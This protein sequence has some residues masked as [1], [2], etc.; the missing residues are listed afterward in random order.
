MSTLLGGGFI[1][2]TTQRIWKI[3]TNQIMKEIN[4]YGIALKL[5]QRPTMAAQVDKIMMSAGVQKG[6]SLRVQKGTD[7][8]VSIFRGFRA[9]C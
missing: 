7:F 5:P 2:E 3:Q 8:R 9:S 6:I 4:S 1:L